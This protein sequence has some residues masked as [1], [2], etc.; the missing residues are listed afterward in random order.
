MNNLRSMKQYLSNYTL[1]SLIAIVLCLSACATDL[2]QQV[3]HNIVIKNSGRNRISDVYIDYGHPFRFEKK[4]IPPNAQTTD[5]GEYPIPVRVRASWTTSE[6]KRIET[7]IE[8]KK[9]LEYAT[10]LRAVELWINEDTLEVYQATP[11]VAQNEFTDRKR[12]Y[13][14]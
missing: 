1:L 5:S 14:R 9:N 12:I 6:G 8:L 11:R 10:R 13:P 4:M 7:T 2:R 3:D